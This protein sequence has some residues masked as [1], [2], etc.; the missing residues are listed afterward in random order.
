M[1]AGAGM[2]ALA[3]YGVPPGA[4]ALLPY[5][6][7]ALGLPAG[8]PGGGLPGHRGAA[9]DPH[10]VAK[11]IYVDGVPSTV[12]EDALASFFAMCGTVIAVRAAP[13]SGA[14]LERRAWVEYDSVDGARM[15]LQYDGTV[16][17]GSTL[18]VTPS[19][20]AIHTNALRGPVASG[21]VPGGGALPGP[22][23]L[24]GHAA[25][26]AAAAASIAVPGGDGN[27]A[28]PVDES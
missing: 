21:G 23:P 16:M 7:A 2:A 8:A 27:G 9:Q 18:R 25:A 4:A 1:G 12:A 22:P 26:A 14:A 6:A 11:T 3:P 15:A 24:P 13:P 17:G 19:R 20:T 5:G 28:E 10:R